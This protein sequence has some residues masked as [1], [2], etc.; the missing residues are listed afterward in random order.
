MFIALSLLLPLALLAASY[1]AAVPGAFA[2][3]TGAARYGG[4]GISVGPWLPSR[5]DLL[6]AMN[7]DWVKVYQTSQLRDYPNQRVL[8]RINITY[9]PDEAWVR[10]LYD[11]ARELNAAGV[12]AVE[13][14]NEPNLGAEWRWEKPSP[15]HFTEALC[16]AYAVFKEVTPH[17]IVVSGGLAPTAGTPDGLN[18]D[19]LVYAKKMLDHGAGACFDAFGYHPYGFDQAPEVDPNKH[20]FSFRRAE[21]MV[22]LLLRSGVRGKQ[23]WITEF[24]WVRNPAEEG[25]DCS[26]DPMFANFQWMAVSREVQADYTARAFA[27]ADRNWA[28]AGPMFLWNLN[29]NT[30]PD[31]EYEP[32]CSHLRWYGILNRDGT[33]LPVVSAI[34]NLPQRPP[35]EYRPE[36]GAVVTQLTRTAEAGCTGLMRMGDFTVYNAGYPG[37]FEVQIEAANAPGR[38]FVWTSAA[39]ATDGD[40]VEVFVDARGAAPGLYLIAINLRAFGT[41]RMSSRVVRGWLL[42]HHPSTPQC[43]QPGG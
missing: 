20:P 9:W 37:E 16:A 40:T 11:L 17:I 34:Q 8:Y 41:E 5:P 39:T 15:K 13:I 28:W 21:L 26:S 24:G 33:P 30:Y 25:L 32:A 14:G 31:Y 22:D 35:V 2:G 12:D 4:Y 1:H 36:I 6:D 10:G 3:T 19:D 43:V 7:M 23:M 42:V 29:W 27:F 18:M 38:P